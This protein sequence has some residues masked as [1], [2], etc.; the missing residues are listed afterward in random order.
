MTILGDLGQS[1]YDYRSID[2]MEEF[3]EGMQESMEIERAFIELS[4]IPIDQRIK[5]RIIVMRLLKIGVEIDLLWLNPLEEMVKFL[6][7][8]RD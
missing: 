4:K 7:L 1:I 5:L 2:K 3:A 8:K 6:P